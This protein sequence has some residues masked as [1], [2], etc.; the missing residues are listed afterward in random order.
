MSYLIAAV[1]SNMGIGLNNDL[2]WTILRKGEK[3]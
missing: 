2:P 3:I 1:D